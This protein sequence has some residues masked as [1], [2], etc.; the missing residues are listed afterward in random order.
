MA[1]TEFGTREEPPQRQ[2][3]VRQALMNALTD[4]PN[5]GFGR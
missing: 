5:L 1:L 4:G 2:A 3:R